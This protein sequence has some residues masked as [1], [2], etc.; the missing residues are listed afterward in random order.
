MSAFDTSLLPGPFSTDPVKN[1]IHVETTTDGQLRVVALMKNGQVERR[2]LLDPSQRAG[3]SESTTY[4]EPDDEDTGD[5]AYRQWVIAAIADLYDRAQ[6]C[7]FCG[8]A[9]RDVRKLITGPLQSI[10]DDCVEH[11]SDILREDHTV[12]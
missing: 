8:K 7:G 5:D 1:G 11:C 10:C 3:Q 12:S 6:R 4:F 9:S 2:V